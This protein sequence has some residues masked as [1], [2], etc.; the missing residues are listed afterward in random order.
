MKSISIMIAA[1]LLAACSQNPD[2]TTALGVKGS[3]AWFM[4]ATPEAIASHYQGSCQSYGHQP[5]SAEMARC[6]ER[7]AEG[8]RVAGR[9]GMSEA[10]SRFGE[11]Q[12]AIATQP[13]YSAP[14]AASQAINCQSYAYPGTTY[15]SITCN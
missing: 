4:T 5:G 8:E 6:V 11:Q 7:S 1:V 13:S 3:P 10:F 9:Q 14:H 15:T 2:G 12:R